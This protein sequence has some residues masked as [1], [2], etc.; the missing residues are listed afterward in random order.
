[1]HLLTGFS[2]LITHVADFG[3]E[4]PPQRTAPAMQLDDDLLLSDDLPADAR[5]IIGEAEAAVADVRRQ[6]ERAVAAV[7]DQADREIAAIRVKA[8]ADAAD[9]QREAA[10]QLSPLLRDLFGRL[11]GVQ[12]ACLRAGDLDGALAVRSRLRSLRGDLFGVR[13]DP[14]N[15][16]DYGPADIGKVML[17]EIVGEGDSDHCWGT[18]VYTGDSRLSVAAV[19]AGAVRPDERALVRVALLDGTEMLFE[20]TERYGVRS[21]DYGNYSIAYTVERV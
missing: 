12:A 1:M 10:A 20:G 18:D 19:H 7:R 6:S 3:L 13:P 5:R 9:A 14:G 15:L 11:K 8:D 17:F 2:R 16:T 21:R 4:R